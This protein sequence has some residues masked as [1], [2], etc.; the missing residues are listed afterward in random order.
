MEGNAPRSRVTTDV[1]THHSQRGQKLVYMRVAYPARKRNER[2]NNKGRYIMVCV[3]DWKE[4]VM[5][6]RSPNT[7]SQN[8]NKPLIIHDNGHAGGISSCACIGMFFCM[9]YL[10][11]I[12]GPLH[13]WT[14]V[15]AGRVPGME[16]EMQEPVDWV[17]NT[18]L[19]NPLQERG[20]HESQRKPM[21]LCRR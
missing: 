15:C 16:W 7:L 6:I 19:S 3:P 5:H 1:D 13:L 17:Q 18:E 10:F 11:H 2:L 21:A 20:A 12:H 8:A 14:M 4:I 9:M